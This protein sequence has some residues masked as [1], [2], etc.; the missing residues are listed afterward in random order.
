MDSHLHIM[1]IFKVL[2]GRYW[3]L[4]D[5]SVVVGGIEQ[6]CNLLK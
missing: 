1:P 2:I 5:V 3:T 4:F 6:D